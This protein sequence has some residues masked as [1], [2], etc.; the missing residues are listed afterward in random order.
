LS[1]LNR[2]VP[3]PTVELSQGQWTKVIENGASTSGANF[4]KL[5]VK[6]NTTRLYRAWLTL[7][8]RA[9]LDTYTRHLEAIA[10]QRENDFYAERMLHRAVSA[11]RA[12]LQS[13]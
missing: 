10:A 11:T 9:R 1:L 13:L 6:A 12:K 7:W 5:T 2:I 3:A 8:L 4:M